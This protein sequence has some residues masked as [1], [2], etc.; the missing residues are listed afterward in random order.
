MART[1]LSIC[2]ELVEGRG[3]HLWPRPG[4]ILVAARSHSFAQLAEAIDDAFARWD[5]SHLHE[6]AL[7]DGP[8]LTTPVE[9]DDFDEDLPAADDRAVRLSCLQGGEQFLYTFDLGDAWTHL[10][11]VAERRV[12]PLEEL[13]IAPTRPL[14]SWGWGDIPDQYGR[15]FE[16]DD[17][18]AELP[19][20]PGLRDLPPLRPWWGMQGGW[21]TR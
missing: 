10:C 19:A 3:E 16:D 7:A 9:D 12:D 17:G 18:E 11:T 2:V 4:R 5:R 21:G 15:R 13:G 20:D 8:R 6:F 14:P 1:W